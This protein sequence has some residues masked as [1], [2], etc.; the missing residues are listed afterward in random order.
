MTN[1]ESQALIALMDLVMA[2][3]DVLEA[4]TATQARKAH[5]RV[6]AERREVEGWRE[7][8]RILSTDANRQ[9]LT[10]VCHACAYP[11]Y[12]RGTG[13]C[14]STG[15]IPPTA[16]ERPTGLRQELAVSRDGQAARTAVAATE[17]R[18][19]AWY[20]LEGLEGDDS[21]IT[22]GHKCCGGKPDCGCARSV[23]G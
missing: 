4:P 3:V 20:G 18:M 19:R 14:F 5:D 11:D 10:G 6:L 16:Q 1:T 7:T 23:G 22:D 9:R 21:R 12:C 8:L 17:R 2:M 13:R 15:A